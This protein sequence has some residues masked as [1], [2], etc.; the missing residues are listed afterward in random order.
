MSNPFD[1]FRDREARQSKGS[2]DKSARW[3]QDQIRRLGLN[4]ITQQ[5]AFKS[6]LGNFV[7]T[8]KTGE[9]L[10]FIYDPKTAD[11]LPYYDT[12]PVV[13]PFKR[14]SD[15]FYGLNFHYLPPLLRMKLLSQMLVLTDDK[16]I[17]ETTR[18]RLQWKLL[19]NVSR[20][21]GV[22]ACVK[23]YLYTQINSRLMRIH[24]ADWK[25]TIML[26]IDNFVKAS[27]QRV[28]SDSRGK[29]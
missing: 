5:S 14:V 17:S 29:M 24:P 6:D 19:N 1:A 26:P 20:F 28:Y 12:V 7:T 10:M 25:K 3:Y 21:P 2:A 22:H 15:G 18:L 16:T 27:R 11:A 13:M 9:M 8:V 23:R 4:S